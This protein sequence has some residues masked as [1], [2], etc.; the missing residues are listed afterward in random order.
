MRELAASTITPAAAGAE[1]TRI[2]FDSFSIS[3]VF[4]DVFSTLSTPRV[5]I[6]TCNCRRSVSR[7]SFHPLHSLSFSFLFLPFLFAFSTFCT[8]SSFPICHSSRR[9]PFLLLPSHQTRTQP[10]VY[11]R[12]S[13]GASHSPWGPPKDVPS[14]A[15]F[16]LVFFLGA[17]ACSLSVTSLLV[18]CA[19]QTS[20]LGTFFLGC[21]SSVVVTSCLHLPY[22]LVAHF[23]FPALCDS[24]KQHWSGPDGIPSF[25]LFSVHWL[26]FSWS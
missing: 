11:L 3:F 14:S 1:P 8:L 13:L 2:E 22:A 7:V 15:A 18:E 12:F 4:S 23:T 5:C 26:S 9:C 19:A 21:T 6:Y 25:P 24:Y 20:L 10:C 17:H 16:F